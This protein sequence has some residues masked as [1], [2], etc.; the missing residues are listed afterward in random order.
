M[1]DNDYWRVLENFSPMVFFYLYLVTFLVAYLLSFLFKREK[2]PKEESKIV[3]PNVLDQ[4]I[5]KDIHEIISIKGIP[6]IVAKDLPRLANK[7]T[8]LIQEKEEYS[9]I[10]QI[11][12]FLFDLSKLLKI[13]LDKENF[14]Q[15]FQKKV[16][17]HHHIT[18][19]DFLQEKFGNFDSACKILNSCT[20]ATLAPPVTCLK[21]LFVEKKL[22]FKDGNWN[23]EV[24]K[25]DDGYMVKH[26]R[27]EK[28]GKYDPLTGCRND[29]F[30]LKWNFEVIFDK[31][32]KLD[33]VRMQIEEIIILNEKESKMIESTI[34]KIFTKLNRICTL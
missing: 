4:N 11:L 20:Q 7:L 29:M 16:S 15:E 34:Q 14:I 5:F 18:L 21:I 9:Q 12:T 8:V 17:P 27:F 30:N 22:D 3:L 23:I 13:T 31:N 32:F 26:K 10:P 1:V 6:S 25:K 28:G 33:R 19:Q 2:T 24:S